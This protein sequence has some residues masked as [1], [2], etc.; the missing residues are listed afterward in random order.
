MGSFLVL[1]VGD[2]PVS[3]YTISL[4][5]GKPVLGWRF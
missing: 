2:D 5:D 1:T 4:R 3:T